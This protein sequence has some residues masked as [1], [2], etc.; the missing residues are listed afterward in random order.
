MTPLKSI[1]KYCLGCCNN[2]ATE[3]KFCPSEDCFFHSFRFGKGRPKLKVIRNKCLECS[4][5]SP[6]EV[7]NCQF[8]DCSLYQF[9]FGH[10]PKLAGK[11]NI[12]KG[13]RI[14]RLKEC[15]V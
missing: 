8:K 14:Q 7:K 10:N 4:D 6:A 13:L 9:R 1:R 11:C 3:V 2:S 5:Y 15:S 12:P